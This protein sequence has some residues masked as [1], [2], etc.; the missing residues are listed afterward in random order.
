MINKLKNLFYI[1]SFFFISLIFINS[2]FSGNFYWHGTSLFGDF[3]SVVNWL[4]CNALGVDLYSKKNLICNDKQVSLFN[5]GHALLILPWSPTLDFF[6][7]NLLPYFLIF[8]FI[9]LTIKIIKPEK[10]I[11]KLLLFL[12]LIN[13]STFFAYDRLNMDLFVYI[14]AITICFNRVY[15]INWFLTL[16]LSLIKIYPAALFINI[17]FENQKRSL[18]NIFLIII[19][20]FLSS[21]VYFFYFTDYIMYFFNNMSSGKAGYHYLFSLNSLPKVFK[22]I[23][24]IN[25]QALLIIFY[26]L[27]IFSIIKIYKRFNSSLKN[28][29]TDIYSFNSKLFMIGGYLTLITYVIFSNWFYKEIFLIL[30]IPYILRAKFDT[31]NNLSSLLIYLFISKYFFLFIY[32]YFNIHDGIIYDNSIR[33]FSS[34]FLFVMSVKSV[35]DFVIMGIITSILFQKTKFYIRNFITN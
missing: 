23:F 9:F 4:E 21:M 28:L 26:L 34:K 25:Y 32:A 20:I 33:V 12:C 30:M 35:F 18:T 8:I 27:F 3:N 11:E 24:N 14:L 5:Y 13:P 31:K 17:F 6:Y 22:Y 29:G 2:D 19:L 7:R 10:K 16:F 15:F 1:F